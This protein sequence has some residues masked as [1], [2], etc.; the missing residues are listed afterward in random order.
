MRGAFSLVAALVL[1]SIFFP[2]VADLMVEILVKGLTALLAA[3][4]ES[5]PA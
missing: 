2:E 4:S 5:L 3:M 1:L